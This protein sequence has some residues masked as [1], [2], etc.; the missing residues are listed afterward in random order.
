VPHKCP[1]RPGV[2]TLAHAN[3]VSQATS[4]TKW[5]V[6][7]DTHHVG[8]KYQRATT[9]VAGERREGQPSDLP[10]PS[11]VQRMNLGEK[12]RKN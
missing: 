9:R 10:H 2:R 11:F 5:W 8:E 12:G 4:L 6:G 7:L 3:A 1:K